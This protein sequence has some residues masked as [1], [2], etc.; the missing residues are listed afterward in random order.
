M[1]NTVFNH[2]F[3]R[4]RNYIMTLKSTCKKSMSHVLTDKL[5]VHVYL[6]AMSKGRQI[7][8][9]MQQLLCLNC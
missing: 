2:S 5:H 6:I 4:L 3:L 8:T 7:V 1:L 9:F